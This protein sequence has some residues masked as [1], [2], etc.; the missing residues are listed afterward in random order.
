MMGCRALLY[1]IIYIATMR[2]KEKECDY[3]FLEP[4]YSSIYC[5][6]FFTNTNLIIIIKA[7]FNQTRAATPVRGG[8]MH[9]P[10]KPVNLKSIQG[11]SGGE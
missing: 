6:A 4:N 5:N 8:W 7:I 2:E 10:K 3:E 9:S 1:N 11:P